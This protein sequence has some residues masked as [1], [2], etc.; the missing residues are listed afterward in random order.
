MEIAVTI[1][2][3]DINFSVNP[4]T[5]NAVAPQPIALISGL[6]VVDIKFG[7]TLEYFIMLIKFKIKIQSLKWRNRK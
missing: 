7:T 1:K 5:K 2:F 3:L 6:I 4:E